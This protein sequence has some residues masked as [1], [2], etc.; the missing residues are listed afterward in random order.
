[1]Q[2]SNYWQQWTVRRLGR[3]AVIRAGGVATLAGAAVLAGCGRGS[4]SGGG[5]APAT[6]PSGAAG[7]PQKGGVFSGRIN[8]DP[9]TTWMPSAAITYIA[10]WPM[11]PAFNQLVQFDPQQEGKV[12][13][14]LADSWEVA[15]DGKSVVFKLHPGVKFHDGSNFT[16]EDVKATID[17]NK[18]PPG[19]L[20]SSRTAVLSAVDHV[21]TPDPLTAT[22]VLKQPNPSLLVNLANHFA[23]IGAKSDLAKDNI[24]SI[25]NGTGPF[26]LKANTR[27]VGV[28]MERNPSY[29]VPDRPYLDGVKYSIVV[30]ENTAMTDLIA[31]QFHRYFPVLTDNYGRAA[32]ESAG[33]I[34]ET[35]VPAPNRNMLF[36]NT[37]KRPFNDPRVRQAVSL[38]LDR[39]EGVT[40]DIRGQGR[41]GGYMLPGGDWAISSDQLNKVPGYDKSNVAEAKKLLAAA[42][43]TDPLSGSLLNRQDASFQPGMIWVQNT[44]QKTLGWN[45]TPDVK[46]SAAAFAAGAQTQFDLCHWLYSVDYDDPDGTFGLLCTKTASSNWS[47]VYDPDADAL[48]DR[49][50]QTMDANQRKQMVQELEQKYLNNY[51]SLTLYFRNRDDALWNTVHNYK[52]GKF[53]YVNQ[54]FQD[55]WLSKS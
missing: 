44:L 48:F 41:P 13:A 35:T 6:G 55:V 51:P 16:S 42:G 46:D 14:D 52:I 36:F 30:D 23:C 45:F 50:S 1:M 4:N 32:R 18:N 26:K 37:T 15:G 39:N 19:K 29:F 31:G 54:R 17:W 9:P 25:V 10:V 7:P 27:G 53:L 33:K 8:T 5:T 43:V 20:S 11:A 22:F 49:Q 12:I 38:V 47:K 3:R 28:E 34:T 2:D 24:G 40:I 21:E